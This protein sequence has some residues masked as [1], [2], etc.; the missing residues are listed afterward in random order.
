MNLKIKS[1]AFEAL[2]HITGADLL[3]FVLQP[4]GQAIITSCL[5]L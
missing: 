4:A 2:Q 1:E 3:F 5:L